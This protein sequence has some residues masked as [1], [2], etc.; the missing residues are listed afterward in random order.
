VQRLPRP[1]DL[2]RAVVGAVLFLIAAIGLV[3]CTGT[4][5]GYRGSILLVGGV[6]VI[7][8]SAPLT[9]VGA[10]V[11]GL[12]YSA[13]TVPCW[14]LF[15]DAADQ[16]DVAYTLAATA[17]AHALSFIEARRAQQERRVLYA[18]REILHE[19][20]TADPLT[21]LVNRRGFDDMVHKAWRRWQVSGAPLSLLMV[22]IDHFKRL[23][24]TFGH[25]VG[26]RYLQ[27]VAG[28]LRAAL[29]DAAGRV[30]AR[31]GG[32]EFACLI[33]GLDA[34][35]AEQAAAD[36]LVAVRAMP[37]PLARDRRL[38]PVTVSIGV[39]TAR[40]GMAGPEDLI[41]RAD[42]RLYLAKG[43]GRDRVQGVRGAEPDH[44]RPAIIAD[45]VPDPARLPGPVMRSAAAHGDGGQN[46]GPAELPAVAAG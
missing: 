43:A 36:V 28:T 20:S 35:A 2:Y 7:Y 18:Q 27:A 3:I 45:P 44:T 22:D 12:I 19:L 40:V 30:V 5:M 42:R 33:P 6:V 26:D 38:R 21:G 46:A 37:V 32:E 11:M 13:V 24:D 10:T 17:L 41:E 8:L 4:A 23:N 1:R 14:L 15:T 31:F 25:A 16:S 34:D 9:L 39:A 29:P